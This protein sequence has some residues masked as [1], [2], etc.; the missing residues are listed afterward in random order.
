MKKTSV[1]RQPTVVRQV[2]SVRQ[3]SNVRQTTNPNLKVLSS[4]SPPRI[5]ARKR[6]ST[7][8]T[9]NS[10]SKTAKREEPKVPDANIQFW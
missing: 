9:L 4:P 5:V 3:M 8:E 6:P 2:T 10:P 1:T 7:S